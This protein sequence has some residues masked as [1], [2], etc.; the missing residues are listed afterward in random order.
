MTGQKKQHLRDS[1]LTLC[2]L[3]AAF[4]VCFVLKDILIVDDLIATVFIFGVFLVSLLS[5]GYLYGMIAAVVSMLV[6]NYAFVTPYFSFNFTI[7]ENILSALVMIVISLMTSALTTKLKRWQA[8]KADSDRE[9]MRANLL[10]A[11]SHDLRTP[12]TTIYGASSAIL[13]NDHILTDQQ[14]TKLVAGIQE[15]A[16]WLIRMVENLLSITRIDSSTV[17]LI[18]T[19]TA[20]D[21]LIDSVI[22]KFKK[23]YPAA[24]VEIDLPEELVIIP[25][26]AILIQQV[27][28]NLL[29]NA[30]QH[31]IG[32]TRLSLKVF[33]IDGKAIFEIADDGCGI[34]KDR[35]ERIFMGY[36]DAREQSADSKNRNSGIGLSVCSAIIKAHGGSI[37]AEN[38]RDGGAVFRFA[39]STE[40]EETYD[41]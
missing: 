1:L 34:E 10:R 7:R 2:V 37:K 39:L 32:M 27:I 23:R 5:E 9:I 25:M 26:D 31:A 21:E 8:I 12:L 20:L 11:V 38:A 40:V 36:Y 19:P 15:D 28:I 33:A 35:L 24:K 30:V 18:K 16:Q 3:L 41:K 22:I 17:E 14:K 13:E 6:M 29:E 4:A